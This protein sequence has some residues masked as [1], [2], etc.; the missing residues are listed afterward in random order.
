MAYDH[1]FWMTGIVYPHAHHWYDWFRP[2]FWSY[3]FE[4]LWSF[5]TRGYSTWQMVIGVDHAIADIAGNLV[6]GFLKE[7]KT[8][9]MGT[10]TFVMPK[11]RWKNEDGSHRTPSD[12][13]W[14][15]ADAIWH[16]T[17]EEVGMGLKAICSDDEWG[18]PD[19][20]SSD[21]HEQLA[22]TNKRER[23]DYLKAWKRFREYAPGMWD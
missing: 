21:Y 14:R 2:R 11:D 19:S 23:Y 9:Q 15:E 7:H 5:F 10:P 1:K 16:V 6:L 3:R 12:E 17:I 18:R 8:G 4:C 20:S 13:D 22:I